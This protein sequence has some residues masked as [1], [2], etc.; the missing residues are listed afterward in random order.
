M[1]S[2]RIWLLVFIAAMLYL[3]AVFFGWFIVRALT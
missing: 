2:N 3:M 1:S